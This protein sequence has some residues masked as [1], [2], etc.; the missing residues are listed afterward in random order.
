LKKGTSDGNL[1][2]H[3]YEG[4]HT[5]IAVKLSDDLYEKAKIRSKVFE[6]SIAGQI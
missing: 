3:T 5:T 6:R 1:K 2:S 4:A